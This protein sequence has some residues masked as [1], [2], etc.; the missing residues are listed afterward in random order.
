MDP[1]VLAGLHA[2]LSNL[3]AISAG[4]SLASMDGIVGQMTNQ[5][6]GGSVNTVPPSLF[7]APGMPAVTSSLTH[8]IGVPNAMSLLSSAQ[9]SQS[10]ANQMLGNPSNAQQ[11][12][13]IADITGAIKS[14][15]S[16]IAGLY[17]AISS[18]INALEHSIGATVAQFAAAVKAAL[19]TVSI[20]PVTGLQVTV[21]G[22]PIASSVLTGIANAIS[23]AYKTITTAMSTVVSA[24][25]AAAVSI[26]NSLKLGVASL[27]AKL[28]A[29]PCFG[30]LAKSMTGPALAAI[31]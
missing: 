28:N 21:P 11:C 13:I 30:S 7:S 27:M 6:I 12:G 5:V 3:N 23:S 10:L 19:P 14:A 31:I 17:G 16:A 25:D 22:V 4:G 29:D 18:E 20:D 1:T 9:S 8:N 15:E 2:N 24:I 26:E